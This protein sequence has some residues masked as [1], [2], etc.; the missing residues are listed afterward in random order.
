MTRLRNHWLWQTP[1]PPSAIQELAER[2]RVPSTVAEILWRRQIHTVEAYQALLT[3]DGPLSDP[4]LLPDM[5]EAVAAISEA[6]ERRRPIRV[7]GDYDADGV[8]ATALL[9]RGLRALGGRVDYYIPNRFDEGY[10]L[11]SDAVQIAHDEG[12]E[13][14][15]TV[16]C[17][18]S[19]PDAA[20]LADT[21]GLTLVITDHHGLPARLPQAR[22]LVN[23]ERR[24]PVDRLSGAGVALQVLRALSPAKE[25]DD[26]YYAVASIGTVA[27]VVPLTG[28]NRRLVARGLKALQ[29]GLVPGVSVLLAHQHRDVQA[30]QVDDL[31]FFIGPRLNAAGR[32]GDAK[33]AVELL[34]AE[35]EAEAD[36]WAQQ[37][38]EANAQRRAQEQTI[39]A[40]AW[41][42]L[43]TRPDGRLYPFCVVAGDGW[44]HGV[45]GIVAS[46][47]KDVVRR[48]VAVIGWNGGD[49]KGS[50]RSVEGVHLLEHM[51][52][53]SELFLALGGHRGAAGFSLLR[54]P[55]DVLSRRL[56]DGLS[57]AAHV[58]PY[59]GVRYD[60]RL[61][62]S[63][64]TEE[65]AVRLQALEPF[66]HGFERPVWLIQGVVA[67]A[68]TMGSDGLHLRLSLRDT[69][70]R[71]VGFHLGIYADGL[72]P[73]TPVQFLGQIE[74]NWFRQRWV[75]Q[76]RITEW[77]WPYPRKAVSYQSGLPSQAES[78]ERRTIYVTE[79][80]REVR[81][82]ARLLSAWPFSPSEPVGQL[83]YWEQALLRGQYNRVVVSQWHLWPRLWG[84][85]DDVVWLTFP[86]SRRRFE[87]S[88]AWL[89]PVGQLWWSPDGQGNAPNVYRKWQRL[90]PT[91][92]RLAQS[93]R[94][95][96]EGRQGLQIGRQIVKDLGLSPDW[97]PRDGK[98][99][100]DRSFQYRWTQYEWID[101]RQWLTKEGNH[102]AM[103]AIRTRNT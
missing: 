4:R 95:W 32:M 85:A 21:L 60:A 62:A 100:L 66:G 20:Q 56:S 51:R 102:D 28:N 23:P 79:S 46:R 74:W 77:L 78:A 12:V 90:L 89:S 29:T 63:E 72:E 34:L 61:E 53:T 5:S 98:V 54:Q 18:S 76:C 101:A 99:P 40:E 88:A 44:H 35:T 87:E 11:N 50:A 68:R 33:G 71:M 16:D 38:A 42:Q 25:V 93:W 75:P 55:A 2:L 1:V 97:T 31:G 7:Y 15:V 37:L 10:G 82:W 81:E 69:S 36:P 22:A 30:C 65:L 19:S 13:L 45:I 17:G 49:G 80:P 91:R 3:Q 9:V 43:P 8:T 27:D 94:H 84:W 103:A 14:L 59:I 64:L 86:R 39:V 92:E 52:Q 57:E 70:M 67:D 58:Q 41:R 6:L 96:V 83:A 48:P 73:G 47:L 24:Q 26:W